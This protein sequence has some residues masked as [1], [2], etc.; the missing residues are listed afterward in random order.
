[1]CGRSCVSSK[2]HFSLEKEP[3]IKKK[4]IEKFVP[5]KADISHLTKALVEPQNS[6]VSFHKPKIAVDSEISYIKVKGKETGFLLKLFQRVN[7]FI[8][9]PAV[10]DIPAPSGHT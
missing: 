9:Q 10:S 2:G 8:Y 6:V 4:Q 3:T 1:M 5:S 7:A